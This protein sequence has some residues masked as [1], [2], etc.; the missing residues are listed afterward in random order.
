[1]KLAIWNLWMKM[2]SLKA[3]WKEPEKYSAKEIDDLNDDYA[4]LRG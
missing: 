3:W 2:K 1:M 4:G